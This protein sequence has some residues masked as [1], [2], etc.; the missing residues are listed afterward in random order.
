MVHHRAT[1]HVLHELNG[2]RFVSY[3]CPSRGSTQLCA[4]R[5]ELPPATQGMPHRVSHEEVLLVLDGCADAELDGVRSRLDPGD[6]LV[7]PA[8]ARISL[9]TSPDSAMSAWL[10]TSVGLQAELPDGTMLAPAWVS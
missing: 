8:G 6:V 9:G 1:D 7:I 4:W 5:V 2:T 3:V 10:T